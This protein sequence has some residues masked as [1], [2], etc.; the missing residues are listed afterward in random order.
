MSFNDYAPWSFA[1][2]CKSDHSNFFS[3]IF[4]VQWISVMEDSQYYSKN[5]RGNE[6][7]I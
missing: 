1:Q 5:Y 7:Q 2:D 6:E 4:Q 3:L